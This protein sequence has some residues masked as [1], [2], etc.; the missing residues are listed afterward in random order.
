MAS[1]NDGSLAD[2]AEAL[3]GYQPTT[4]EEL[5]AHSLRQ[6]GV[7]QGDGEDDA[8]VQRLLALAADHFIAE[9]V[10][11]S[12]Q[13]QRIRTGATTSASASQKEVTLTLEDA[14]RGLANVG[15]NLHRVDG[16]S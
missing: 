16:E 4:P 5:V 3:K 10:H 1:G 11:D 8:L 13:Y 12:I 2:F 15:I 14:Q 7:N 6:A 9:V